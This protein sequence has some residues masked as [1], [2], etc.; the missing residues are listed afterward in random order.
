MGTDIKSTYSATF[1]N[2]LSK[3]ATMLFIL[4]FH[5]LYCTKSNKNKTDFVVFVLNHAVGQCSLNPDDI[6]SM[7]REVYH[8]A[9]YYNNDEILLSTPPTETCFFY[10][11]SLAKKLNMTSYMTGSLLM[12]LYFPFKLL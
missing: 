5:I 12:L 1:L 11:G 10:L 8:D 3:L 6:H 4:M 9:V 2:M 7:I